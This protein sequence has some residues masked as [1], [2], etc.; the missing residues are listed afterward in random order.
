MRPS[1]PSNRTVTGP[2]RRALTAVAATVVVA[3]AVVLVPSDP[4]AATKQPGMVVELGKPAEASFPPIPAEYPRPFTVD[5]GI[6][7]P[8]DCATPPLSAACDTVP[9]R[10]IPPQLG[11]FDDWFVRVTLTWAPQGGLLELDLYFWDDMQSNPGSYTR[12]TRS[13]TALNPEKVE[14]IRPSLGQYNLTISNW[15]GTNRGYKVRV[16]VLK[17]DPFD[18]PFESTEPRPPD[19][20]GD[21]PGAPIEDLSS[22]FSDV[23]SFDDFEA[24]FQ[25]EELDVSTDNPFS[26]S[27]QISDL[28]AAPSIGENIVN[29]APPGP[30]SGVQMFIWLVLFPVAVVGGVVVFLLRRSTSIGGFS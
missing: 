4:A 25:F 30:A 11:P 24:A 6:A 2:L 7:T 18:A 21:P 12:I 27:N 13:Q 10:I 14:V 8:S 29:F 1:E 20:S 3:T 23:G 5:D 19:L 16:E 9:L 17:G 22:D 15:H 26:V 28:P